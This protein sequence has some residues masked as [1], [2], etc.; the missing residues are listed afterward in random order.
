[1]TRRRATTLAELVICLS[2]G[3]SI[4][5]LAIKVTHQAMTASS[6]ARQRGD[7]D[8]AGARLAQQLRHDVHRA[9]DVTVEVPENLRVEHVDE[10]VTTYQADRGRIIRDHQLA[11]GQNEREEYRLT[12][13]DALEFRLV[14]EPKRVQ[15]TVRRRRN[16]DDVA[17]TVRLH[18]V[19]A[20]GKMVTAEQA[21][22]TKP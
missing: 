7:V 22:E 14:E 15:L 13:D 2:I 1:M 5:L 4:M 18:V 10:T 3:S 9:V 20:V 12:D 16:P 8:R 19:A 11:D 6:Q 17:T 21:S